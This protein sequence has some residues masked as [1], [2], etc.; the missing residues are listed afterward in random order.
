MES[1]DIL[2]KKVGQL[3]TIVQ[4]LKGENVSLKKKISALEKDIQAGSSDIDNLN[5][6]KEKTKE[7]IV[8]LIKNI[9]E[10]VG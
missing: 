8:S 2:E 9:D 5:S 1:L 10:L 7:L 4:A 3:V 6:E